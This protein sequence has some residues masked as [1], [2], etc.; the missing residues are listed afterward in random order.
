MKLFIVN[1][2]DLS[3]GG[4]RKCWMV[5]AQN[6]TNLNLMLPDDFETEEIIRVADGFVGRDRRL[7]SCGSW[8]TV[9]EAAA[10]LHG[11]PASNPPIPAQSTSD[12]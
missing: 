10:M 12:V 7:G 8:A 6:P 2:E 1:G 3:K 11:M 5:I 4:V 9:T